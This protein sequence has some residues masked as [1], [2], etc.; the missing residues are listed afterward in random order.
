MVDDPE[1]YEE[2]SASAGIAA[3]MLTRGNPLH[4][5]LYQQG[6]QRDFWQMSVKTVK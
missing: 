1:S 2:I 6:N 3:A 5:K 4:S